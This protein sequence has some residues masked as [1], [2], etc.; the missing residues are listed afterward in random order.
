MAHVVHPQ[1][2]AWLYDSRVTCCTNY[3]CVVSIYTVMKQYKYGFSLH[4]LHST[5]RIYELHLM[6]KVEKKGSKCLMLDLPLAISTA[7]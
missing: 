7:K 2:F 1:G 6:L 4:D 5:M 3:M